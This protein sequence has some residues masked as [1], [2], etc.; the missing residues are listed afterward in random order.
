MLISM[1]ML[2]QSMVMD[3]NSFAVSIKHQ[4]LE[5]VDFLWNITVDSLK[6]SFHLLL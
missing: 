6:T 3:Y 4:F 5:V 1:A 2:S